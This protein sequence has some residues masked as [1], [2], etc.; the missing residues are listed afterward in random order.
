M[1]RQP[2]TQE[3]VAGFNLGSGGYQGGPKKRRRMMRHI[4]V[5]DLEIDALPAEAKDLVQRRPA[6]VV[7]GLDKLAI[8][9]IP[10][11]E[12]AEPRLLSGADL[13]G[14]GHVRHEAAEPDVGKPEPS[15]R[16][17][18]ER[19]VCRGR[20]WSVRRLTNPNPGKERFDRKADRDKGPAQKALMLEAVAATPL[21][22]QFSID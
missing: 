22:E 12:S 13:P 10:D 19:C 9:G 20:G 16:F 21:G 1:D 5:R 15:A 18:L 4:V 7:Q 11:P 3:R 14:Q 6:V 17:D 2:V 8:V